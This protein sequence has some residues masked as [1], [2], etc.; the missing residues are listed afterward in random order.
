[1][2]NK[3]GLHILKHKTFQNRRQNKIENN[4]HDYYMYT[5]YQDIKFTTTGI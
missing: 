3:N 2:H 1:M 4:I 5:I